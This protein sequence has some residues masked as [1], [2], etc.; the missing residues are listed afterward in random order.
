MMASRQMT[1]RY[2]ERRRE[3]CLELGE[4]E[5]GKCRELTAEEIQN[6]E[7]MAE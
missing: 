6:L 1:G 2:L 3:G 7:S 5:R 4:L